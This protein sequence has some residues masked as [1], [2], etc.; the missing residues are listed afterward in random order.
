MIRNPFA[1]SKQLVLLCFAISNLDA[2]D[3]APTFTKITNSPILAVSGFGTAWADY[4]RDGFPDLFIGTTVGNPTGNSPNQLYR[5]RGD[6]T[7][8]LVPSNAFPDGISVLSAA[9]ADYD[10]DGWLDLLGAKIGNDLLYHNQGDGTFSRVVN[11]VSTDGGVGFGA[12]WGDFNND[13]LVDLFV[14]HEINAPNALYQ[15]TGNGSFIAITNPLLNLSVFSQA[16]AWGDYDNDGR[17]DLVVANYRL[18]KNLLYHNEG[19]GLF[20]SIT[21]SPVVSQAGESESCAWGDYDNDGYLDLFVGT[22]RT[23]NNTLYHNNRDGTFSTVADSIVSTDPTHG[24][25]AAWGDYDND[26]HLDLL[27]NSSTVSL[28]RNNGHGVFIAVTNGGLAKDVG[29]GR[30]CAWIDYNRD[31]FLDAW[32]ARTAGDPNALF[33]NDHNSNGWLVVQCEGRLSNRAAIGAKVRLQ[34]TIDG[35]TFWQLRQIGGYELNAH[36]GLGNA[37]N[38]M[39]VRIEWP[40]GIVQELRDVPAKQ[41]LTVVEPEARITP[42]AVDVDA[43][44]SVTFTCDTTF[45]PPI[46]FQWR[47]NGMPLDGETN[48]TLVTPDVQAQHGGSYSVMLLGAGV[49]FEV[50]PASLIGPVVFA[51]QPA[52]Q[53]VRPGSN[54]VITV[55]VTGHG[56]LSYQWRVKGRDIAG[57]NTS[58]LSLSNVQLADAGIYNVAVSNTFGVFVSADAPVSVLIRPV[59]SQQPLSQTVVDGGTLT[60]SASVSAGSP[61]PLHFLWRMNNTTITNLSLDST[62]CFF[63]ITNLQSTAFTN[64]INFRVAVTNLAGSSLLSSNAAVTIL[65][66]FDHD[67]LPDD[68]ENAHGFNAADPA[69][70]ALDSDGDTLSN[71]Q[72]YLAGTDPFDAQSSLRIETITYVANTITLH[73]IALSNR[74]YTIETCNALPAQNWNRLTD[75][76]AAPTN[77]MFDLLDPAEPSARQRF[78]RI[79]SPRKPE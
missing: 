18:N 41:W 56:P 55:A 46:Q 73:F 62:H 19:N 17:I 38:A 47:R 64:V 45:P 37:T 61:F 25:S 51:Q 35:E 43:G 42:A 3:V 22:L 67:G 12:V 29:A 21:N 69:D 44:A 52:P 79:I 60:L 10:N 53:L 39:R 13:G 78:Y 5:N 49:A 16:A 77:R 8:E 23:F 26:G 7:F 20:T 27:V 28:Y 30:S 71:L 58:S 33:K 15:N 54:V 2:A 74:T 4:D 9:W 36:F 14:A 75:V 48:S 32:L 57:A 68:W 76:I 65:A 72:E 70:A 66:D 59:F 40:S 63:T 6:G 1:P 50:P 11:A 24:F 31:G 34:A